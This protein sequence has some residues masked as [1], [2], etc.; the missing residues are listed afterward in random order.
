MPE[1]VQ[2]PGKPHFLEDDFDVGRAEPPF[3]IW[4]LPS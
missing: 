4:R 1:R 2:V 3:R